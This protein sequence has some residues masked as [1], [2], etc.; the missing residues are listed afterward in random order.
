LRRRVGQAI[1]A[2]FVVRCAPRNLDGKQGPDKGDAD[3]QGTMTANRWG[4]LDIVYRPPLVQTAGRLV[5]PGLAS[6]G[7]VA[8]IYPSANGAKAYFGTLE[9]V[10]RIDL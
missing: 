6:L 8:P 2:C 9:Q 10:Y 3:T 5:G 4:L 1:W 7:S